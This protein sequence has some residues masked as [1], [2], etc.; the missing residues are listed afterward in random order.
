M[1]R[2][3]NKGFTLV[4]LIATIVLLALVM[5]IGSYSITKVIENSK[6]KDYE[7]LIEN[8]NNAAEDYYIECEYGGTASSSLVCD[9][10]S[11]YYSVSLGLLVKYGFLTGNAK[12]SSD[13]YTLVN[14]NDDKNI[15]GCAIKI[16]YNSGKVLVEASNPTGSC[17]TSY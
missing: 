8:I 11:G 7:L 13:E 17:P 1:K 6:K 5:G 2:I 12:D 10:S 14:P 3:D 16:N 9:N 15:A 4:E